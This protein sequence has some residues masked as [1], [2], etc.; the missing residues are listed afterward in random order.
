MERLRNY[1]RGRSGNDRDPTAAR[2]RDEQVAGRFLPN[3][4]MERLLRL[5]ATDRPAF[6]RSVAGGL[7]IALGHYEAAK[8]AHDRLAEEST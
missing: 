4:G 5:R 1:H 6:D 8:T 7:R 3:E 2:R